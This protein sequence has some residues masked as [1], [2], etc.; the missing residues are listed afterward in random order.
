MEALTE[1]DRHE[2]N[3]L[4]REATVF[5]EAAWAVRCMVDAIGSVV[6]VENSGGIDVI[7]TIDFNG[8]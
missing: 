1:H 2:A 7:Q 6:V 8:E 5:S 4:P 3:N